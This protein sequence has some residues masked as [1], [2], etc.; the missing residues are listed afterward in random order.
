MLGTL[1]YGRWLQPM[2][3]T[4]PAESRQVTPQRTRVHMRSIGLDSIL[5]YL[6]QLV[7]MRYEREK[8]LL[9]MEEAYPKLRYPIRNEQA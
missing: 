4:V 2:S 7:V 5:Q 9:M 1:V 8:T 3:Y 6:I